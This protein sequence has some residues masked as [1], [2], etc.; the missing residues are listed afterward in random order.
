MR[1]I[2]GGMGR[3]PLIPYLAIDKR[4]LVRTLI[5]HIFTCVEIQPLKQRLKQ[6]LRIILKNVQNVLFQHASKQSNRQKQNIFIYSLMYK[7]RLILEK[8]IEFGSLLLDQRDAVE[9]SLHLYRW[10]EKTDSSEG[11]RQVSS[12][13]SYSPR[14]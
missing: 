11:R 10:R 1:I 14:I 7:V 9:I 5:F 2:H 4:I 3:I 13:H 12:S 6:K 8:E